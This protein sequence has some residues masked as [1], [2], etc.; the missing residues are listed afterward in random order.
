MVAREGLRRA[1]SRR[2]AGAQD[3]GRAL[4][5][6]PDPLDAAVALEAPP[7][8]KPSNH[9]EPFASRPATRVKRRLSAAFGRKIFGVNPALPPLGAGSA[10]RHRGARG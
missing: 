10:L 2:A 4:Q 5:P 1:I 7:W 6:M 9:P 3:R 8:T